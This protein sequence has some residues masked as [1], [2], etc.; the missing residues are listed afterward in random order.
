[1]FKTWQLGLFF[2]LCLIFALLFNWPVKQVL[3]QMKLPDTVSLSGINGT[4]FNGT[5]Q[6]ISINGFP[7]RALDYSYQPSC[8]VLLKVCYKVSYEQG[9]F[10]LAYDVLNDDTEI[11]DARVEYPVSELLKHVP[12]VPVHPVGRVELMVDDLSMVQGE[13]VGLNGKLIWRDMGL[14]DDV[15][16]NLGDYQIVFTGNQ[17]Q[18]DFKLS[19]LDASLDVTGTGEIKADGQYSVDIKIAAETTIVPRVKNVLDLVAA[20]AAYNQYRFEQKGSL[21]P[22]FT[23]QLFR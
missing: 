1:M 23:R 7:L 14:D 10:Q 4:V 20:K 22:N 9:T 5:V 18:Y 17:K 12:N 16:I 19:D 21:P 13:P 3:P 11:S 15:K 8:I 2:L 6:E